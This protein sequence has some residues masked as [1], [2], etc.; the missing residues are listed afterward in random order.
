MQCLIGED[1]VVM[2]VTMKV[3]TMIDRI[4]KSDLC[5]VKIIISNF[6]KKDNSIITSDR[7]A[8]ELDNE[9]GLINGTYQIKNPISIAHNIIDI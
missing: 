7:S 5:K 3:E 1:D 8:V 2:S 9:V 4:L 6:Q